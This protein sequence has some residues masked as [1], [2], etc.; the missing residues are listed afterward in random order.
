MLGDGHL[1]LWA[2]QGVIARRLDLPSSAEAEQDFA[3]CEGVLVST[4]HS[5]CPH[6]RGGDCAM[7]QVSTLLGDP[8]AATARYVSLCFPSSEVGYR[9]RAHPDRLELGGRSSLGLVLRATL[10]AAFSRMP[11][12]PLEEAR[13]LVG[14]IAGTI[15]MVLATCGGLACG[16]AS[17]SAARRDEICQFIIDHSRE[18]GI[19]AASLCRHFGLSRATLYRLFKDEGGLMNFVAKVR[20]DQIVVQLRA[21][22]REHGAVSRV[23]REWNYYDTPNF[24]RLFKRHTGL[25]PGRILGA[26]LVAGEAIRV[27]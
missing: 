22:P 25:V 24:Y 4:F 10:D 8:D 12:C 7:L 1:K 13:D 15:R 16:K 11:D 23:A 20:M 21:T 9:Q 27:E 14:A 17:P 18:D 26:D 6:A 3:K 19:C 2:V 5:D